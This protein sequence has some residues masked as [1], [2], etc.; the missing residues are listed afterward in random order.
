[1][2]K[3]QKAAIIASIT[4]LAITG[5]AVNAAYQRPTFEYDPE[6]VCEAYTFTVDELSKHREITTARELY[7]LVTPGDIKNPANRAL[8]MFAIAEM[9]TRSTDPDT[10][11]AHCE[12]TLAAAETIMKGE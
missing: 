11:Q 9:A 12:E 2:N 6:L 8:F 5:L 1:M 4:A 7:A 3:Q 10:A